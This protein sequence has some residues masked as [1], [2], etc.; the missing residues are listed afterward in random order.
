MTKALTVIGLMS[1]TS[2]DGVDVA[3]LETDG[4]TIFAF[5]PT[6]SRPYSAAERR[7]IAEA[8]AQGPGISDRTERCGVVGEA[9]RTVT[10]A[11]AEAVEAFLADNGLTVADI[12]VVGFHGQTIFHR[13]EKRLTVQI[14]DGPALSRRLGIDVVHDFR[15][16]D[17]A[18]G[19]QG[20]PFVPVYHR[21]LAAHAGLDLPV[22]VLNLGGVGNVTYLSGEAPLAFDTGPANALIDDW[23]SARVGLAFDEG[24]R[25]AAR[26]RIDEALLAELL[27]GLYFTKRPPK[28]LDRNEFSVSSLAGLSLE[29]GAATLAAFTAASVALARDWFPEPARRWIVVG[30]GAN[31]PTLMAMLRERLDCSVVTGADI[32]WSGDHV[33]AQA[34]AY[35]AV[36]SMRGLPLTFPTSTGVPAPMTGGVLAK[37]R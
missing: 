17:V 32:G 33:E 31:N 13:P 23:V 3:M 21:A 20:A 12:D 19:G 29:D 37:G 27:S 1:G 28:S 8:V 24:G 11:H 22:A 30:G 10:G 6:G 9:E 5:G 14:G 36:R 18:A 2:M 16:A 15:A 34:F 35:M 26:G 4:E 7:T 25:I